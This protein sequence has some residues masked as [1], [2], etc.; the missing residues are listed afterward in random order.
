MYTKGKAVRV[1]QYCTDPTGSSGC[2]PGVSNH[3]DTDTCD[4]LGWGC[5]CGNSH[6]CCCCS[7]WRLGGDENRGLNQ[8]HQTPDLA[9]EASLF[10]TVF[11][12]CWSRFECPIHRA[13]VGLKSKLSSSLLAA[14][15]GSRAQLVRDCTLTSCQ[16]YG[17]F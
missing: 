7:R 5:R 3:R 12:I 15:E 11:G 17:L 9:R 14:D 6:P 13:V 1:G 8:T 2:R 4:R 16:P 10:Y